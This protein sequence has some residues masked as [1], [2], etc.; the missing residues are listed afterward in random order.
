[1]IVGVRAVARDLSGEEIE[2][3]GPLCELSVTHSN[4]AANPVLVSQNTRDFSA[5]STVRACAGAFSPIVGP[6]WAD[7][8][9]ELFISFIFPFLL[10]LKKFQKMVEKP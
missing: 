9:P 6:T 4:S 10:E 7:F 2:V 8:G 1:V 3:G 5:K